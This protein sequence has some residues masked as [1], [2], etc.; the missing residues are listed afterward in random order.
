MLF[1]AVWGI[2]LL[3]RALGAGGDMGL[4]GA[5]MLLPLAWVP[6]SYDP[7]EGIV[8][9]VLLVDVRGLNLLRWLFPG[10]VRRMTA[11]E[12]AHLRGEARLRAR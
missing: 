4:A 1:T 8:A 7:H 11:E 2:V 12:Y 3:M 9:L 10:Q 6:E 5:V